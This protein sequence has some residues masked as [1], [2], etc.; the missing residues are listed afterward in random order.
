MDATTHTAIGAGNY[1][2]AANGFGVAGDPVGDGFRMFE[3]IGFVAHHSGNDRFV[4]GEV[5]L[6]PNFPFVLMLGIR[7]LDG[8][9]ASSYFQQE[10]DYMAQRQIAAVWAF[11]AAPADV[12]ADLVFRNAAQ[13]VIDQLDVRLGPLPKSGYVSAHR[14]PPFV[15]I[16]DDGIIELQVDSGT[17]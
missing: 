17:G 8:I 4:L 12:I 11:P 1:A 2:L 6:F 13:R 14:M 10:V 9:L 15:H 3:H 7:G 16:D 5:H